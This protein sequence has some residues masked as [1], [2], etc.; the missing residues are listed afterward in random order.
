MVVRSGGI[1][2]MFLCQGARGGGGKLN[3]EKDGRISGERRTLRGEQ[4]GR[5][6][7]FVIMGRIQ[8]TPRW[9]DDTVRGQTGR[10]AMA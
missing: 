2:R 9:A 8:G 3:T 7:L 10:T 6:G 5:W 4:R 1:G